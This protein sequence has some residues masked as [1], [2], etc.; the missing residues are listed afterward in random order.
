MPRYCW[1]HAAHLAMCAA[2][3]FEENPST[4]DRIRTGIQHYNHSQGIVTTPT[5]GYHETLTLFWIET[6]RGYLKETSPETRLAAVC[7]TIKTFGLAN[8]LPRKRYTFDVFQSTEARARW[9]PP[10]RD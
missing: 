3:L 5:F 1:T 10:D 6:V 2:R 9:I 8:D 4:V 7:G